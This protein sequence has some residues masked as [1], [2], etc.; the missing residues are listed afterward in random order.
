[1]SKLFNNSSI[2][3]WRHADSNLLHIEI[4]SILQFPKNSTLFIDINFFHRNTSREYFL[5]II[6]KKIYPLYIIV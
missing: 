4:V 6:K 3:T 1:M 5:N 2:V